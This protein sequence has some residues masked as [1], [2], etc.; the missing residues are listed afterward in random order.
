ML[1][2]QLLS[3]VEECVD[4]PDMVLGR[5]SIVTDSPVV[6]HVAA[7]EGETLIDFAF[8]LGLVAH[9]VRA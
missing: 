6:D 9:V 4:R 3:N 2:V 1:R 8:L 7:L 5:A